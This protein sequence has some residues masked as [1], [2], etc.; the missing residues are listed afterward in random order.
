MGVFNRDLLR[1]DADAA[2]AAADDATAWAQMNEA[3]H[4]EALGEARA[5]AGQD[6]CHKKSLEHEGSNTKTK[7][8]T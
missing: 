6:S 7:V 5:G 2:H 3:R 4:V 1:S 8:Q